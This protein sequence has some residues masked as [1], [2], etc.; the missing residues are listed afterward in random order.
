MK[1]WELIEALQEHDPDSEVKFAYNYGDYPRTMVTSNPSYVETGVVEYSD[2]H[3]MDRVVSD[4]EIAEE[5]EEFAE[6]QKEDPEV[7]RND[8]FH[9]QN[10]RNVVIIF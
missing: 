3:R 10:R 4:E 1:V 7:T 9:S 6:A 8:L 2:Y 5:D